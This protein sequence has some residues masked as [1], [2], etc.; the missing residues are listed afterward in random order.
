MP[1]GELVFFLHSLQVC[2]GLFSVRKLSEQEKDAR[3][4]AVFG[5]CLAAE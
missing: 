2:L 4:R 3:C 1:N 5:L